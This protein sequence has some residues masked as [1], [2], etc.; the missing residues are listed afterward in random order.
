MLCS[1]CKHELR[2]VEGAGA[3]GNSRFVLGSLLAARQVPRVMLASSQS[4][5]G[6]HCR[7]L[8]QPARIV[9]AQCRMVTRGGLSLQ[10]RKRLSFRRRWT[11]CTC[12]S[13][14]PWRTSASVP[15]R[16][17]L[18]AAHVKVARQGGGRC[19]HERPGASQPG[20]AL[21]P[22]RGCRFVGTDVLDGDG[23][24]CQARCGGDPDRAVATPLLNDAITLSAAAWM[25]PCG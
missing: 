21:Q 10:P 4:S 8:A 5:V 2:G 1:F 6:W 22:S 18:F 17:G 23:G 16:S 13:T 24:V 19:R 20:A 3:C 7:G 9:S 14:R 25:P 12:A 11:D 15:A